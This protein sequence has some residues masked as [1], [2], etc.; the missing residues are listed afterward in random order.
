VI[1]TRANGSKYQTGHTKTVWASRARNLF[2]QYNSL[3]AKRLYQKVAPPPP[4]SPQEPDP[5]NELNRLMSAVD[6]EIMFTRAEYE[7]LIAYM[8]AEQYPQEER[9]E[10]IYF[11]R[12]RGIGF[13]VQG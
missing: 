7:S 3:N 5:M 4:Q 6:L 8:D 9:E 10:V 13:G 11:C 2:A 1:A 12:F